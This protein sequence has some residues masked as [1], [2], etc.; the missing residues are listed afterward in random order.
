[1]SASQ[2]LLNLL[3]PAV[4]I[5]RSTD[6][7]GTLEIEVAPAR[8]YQGVSALR[9]HPDLQ[10]NMLIDI[11]GV[12]YSDMPGHTAGRFGL[13]YQFKSLTKK[14]RVTVKT[15]LPAS[16]PAV[17]SIHDLYK[18]ANWLE[19]EAWDQFGIVFE[20]HPNLKRILNHHEFE[21]HP[22]RKDYP[23][24]RRQTLSVSDS[25]QDQMQQRLASKGYANES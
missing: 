24:T 21:G 18:N 4:E 20:N 1:M 17:P 23:I 10:M 12:D 13:I 25:L 9:D 15:N 6:R 8:L 11:A 2:T 19:R 3:S 5:L 22:L 14:H 7:F 16:H